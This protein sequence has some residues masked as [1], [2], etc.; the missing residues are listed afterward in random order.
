MEILKNVAL[1]LV[2]VL[3]VFSAL[4][5]RN[6][7]GNEHVWATVLLCLSMATLIVVQW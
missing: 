7:E 1:V 3:F 5:I 4:V 2:T 6:D